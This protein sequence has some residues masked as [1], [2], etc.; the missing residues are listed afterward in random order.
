MVNAI[1]AFK[2]QHKGVTAATTELV[3]DYL[4][5][6]MG[7]DNL[8]PFSF[9]R[10]HE[11]GRPGSPGC[12]ITLENGFFTHHTVNLLCY[13]RQVVDSLTTSIRLGALKAGVPGSRFYRND[14]QSWLRLSVVD[15]G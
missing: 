10:H 13:S 9:G 7:I 14:A 12:H 2:A 6:A 4:L 8:T 15:G 3:A 11:R 5:T 1:A